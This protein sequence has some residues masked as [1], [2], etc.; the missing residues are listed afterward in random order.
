[1]RG[2][3]ETEGL[4]DYG[5]LGLSPLARGNLTGWPYVDAQ[6]GPIPACAGEPYSRHI[7]RAHSGAYP[8]LRGGTNIVD[9]PE[10]GVL[11]LSPLARGNQAA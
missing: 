4:K 2:G 10:A 8:R 9:S 11:G 3:T 5:F 7:N 6:G 1:M